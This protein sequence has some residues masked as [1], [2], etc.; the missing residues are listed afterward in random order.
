MD[1]QQHFSMNFH[2][3]LL[4]GK[5]VLVWSSGKLLVAKTLETLSNALREHWQIANRSIEACSG[6]LGNTGHWVSFI[7]L[8]VIQCVVV[9]LFPLTSLFGVISVSI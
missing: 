5:L 3:L 8:F 9:L 2:P 6:N 7:V 1:S 4:R